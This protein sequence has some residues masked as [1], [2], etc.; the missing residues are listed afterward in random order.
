LESLD[1]H[2][3]AAR[4]DLPGVLA[5]AV[6]PGFRWE[7]AQGFADIDTEAALTPN[8][9]FR[10]GSVSKTFLAAIVLGLVED[11]ALELDRDAGPIA[12]GVTIR[13]LLNHTSGFQEAYDDFFEA[14]RRDRAHDWESAPRKLI[15]AVKD[16]PRLFAPGN[17]WS[18]SNT[19][20]LMLEVIVEETTGA[21]LREELDRRI[22]KPLG[23]TDTALP[24]DRRPPPDLARGYLPPDNPLI[25][26]ADL[27]DVTDLDLPF[28]STGDGGVV[29]TARDVARF[30]EGLLGGEILPPHLQA[31]LLTAVPSDW[32]ESDTYG[33]GIGEMTSVMREAPSPCGAAWGH[34]GLGVGYTTIALASATGERRV[35]V[36]VNASVLSDCDWDAL[37]RLTWTAYCH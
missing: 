14:L 29:S 35:V 16:K 1:A 22:V 8:H 11:G 2:L 24:A 33:L 25:P 5:L 12:D 28:N 9:R 19:N 26:A 21:T 10:I 6:G 20:Y 31:E 17:G 34:L 32:D 15:A 4:S 30:L 36:M 7:G 27:V 13:E 37:G 23:L 3:E 18:Y